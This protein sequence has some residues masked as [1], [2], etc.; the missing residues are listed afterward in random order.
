[1]SGR[2]ASDFR[3]IGALSLTVIVCGN[4]VRSGGR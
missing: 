3:A 2:S 4:S 1:M